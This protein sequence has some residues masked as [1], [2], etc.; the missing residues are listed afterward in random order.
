VRTLSALETIGLPDKARA[1]ADD[2]VDPQW[3]DAFSIIIRGPETFYG[4][5][6]APLRSLGRGDLYDKIATKLKA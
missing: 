4:K 1:F 3:L 5:L 6:I 2:A